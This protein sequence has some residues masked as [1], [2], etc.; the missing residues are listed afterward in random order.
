MAKMPKEVLEYFRKQGARGGKKSG[1]ARMA[2]LTP[3]QRTEIAKKA[4]AARWGDA[5]RQ[6]DPSKAHGDKVTKSKAAPIKR[7]S[8]KKSP[9]K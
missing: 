5:K 3:E 6:E 2:K 4:A 8:A 7:S 1:A 9:P